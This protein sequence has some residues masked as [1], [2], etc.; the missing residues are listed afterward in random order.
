M[1][2]ET[3]DRFFRWEPG[4]WPT[5]LEQWET[6]GFPDDGDFSTYFDMDPL[7]ILW[8]VA[9]GFTDSP[10]YPKFDEQTLEE[11]DT[12]RT[13]VDAFGVRKR[14]LKE[15]P[16][17]SMPQ[18]LSYPVRTRA[19]WGRMRQRFDPRDAR[20]RLGDIG[21]L[22]E[23]CAD[24]AVPTMLLACGAYGHPRNLFGD[25]GL[26][27]VI[28]EDPGLLEEILD[29]WVEVYAELLRELTRFA[30]LDVLLLWEDMCFKG[31]PLMSPDDFGR[32]MVPRY[33]TLTSVAPAI[34][35][36]TSRRT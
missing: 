28:C 22:Q 21:R 32:Y 26:A 33:Q 23:A 30:R 25:V 5:T 27:Y 8:S 34:L 6:Q 15:H 19:D 36:T 35:V 1:K 29:N 9:S 24:P 14:E 18:F 16:D 3:V 12:T 17:T 11:D 20:G 31:G 13:Y 7:R 2:G 4:P 10:V